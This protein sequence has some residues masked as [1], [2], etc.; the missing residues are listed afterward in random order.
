MN[1]FEEG[2]KDLK[3]QFS[4]EKK[5]NKL[6]AVELERSLEDEVAL[7][8]YSKRLEADNIALKEQLKTLDEAHKVE[9][10][11]R[12]RCQQFID[13]ALRSQ[14]ILQKK[15]E[16]IVYYCDKDVDMSAVSILDVSPDYLESLLRDVRSEVSAAWAPAGYAGSSSV[17]FRGKFDFAVL[18][19][20]QHNIDHQGNQYLNNIRYAAHTHSYPIVVEL[21]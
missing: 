17:G 13:T 6:L 19:H 8:S 1:R 20:K 14:L 18:E 2:C 7:R 15:L 3:K 5:K 11:E 4:V 9:V 12:F 16:T 10:E 21:C